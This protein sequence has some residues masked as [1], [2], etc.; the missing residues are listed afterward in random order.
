[1]LRA[2]SMPFLPHTLEGVHSLSGSRQP[3]YSRRSPHCLPLQVPGSGSLG[4]R[5]PHPDHGTRPQALQ[6][7]RKHA[8]LSIQCSTDIDFGEGDS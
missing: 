5:A 1:M 8:E 2:R 3:A 7:F 4:N 6:A